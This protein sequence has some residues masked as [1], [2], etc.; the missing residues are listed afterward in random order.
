M[1]TSTFGKSFAVEP[2][3]SSRFVREMKKTAPPTL[4]KDFR[5]KYANLNTNT[6]LGEKITKLLGK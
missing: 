1:A 4:N 6:A 5:S 3:E 2:R